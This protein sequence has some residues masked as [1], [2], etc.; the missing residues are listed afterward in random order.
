MKLAVVIALA[1]GATVSAHAQ[2]P[3]VG[4][5]AQGAWKAMHEV[6]F[7]S[8][9]DPETA[10]AQERAIAKQLWR[11]ELSARM[12]N[13]TGYFPGFA[14]L[15]VVQEG[16]KRIVLSMFAAARAPSCDPAP[17]GADEKDIYVECRLRVATWP[18]EAG[19][20]SHIVD[21]PG[22]CMV[23]AAVGTNS[24]TEY[25]YDRQA[26]TV[27]FRTLQFGQVVPKCT[28]SLKLD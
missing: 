22:Y 14:Q 16:S 18:V 11:H 12:R 28:R 15:A 4:S 13:S 3:Q 21:L 2:Q 17:N 24:R 10:T 1:M 6:V 7:D 23:F 27:H 26:Q 20:V 8:P 25:R 5:D 19:V 9:S